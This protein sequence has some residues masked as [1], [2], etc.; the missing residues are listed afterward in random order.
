[1]V[2]QHNCNL[3]LVALGA[4]LPSSTGL[5]A[6]TLSQALHRLTDGGD[7]RL[8][9]LS[10]FWRTP[11]HPVGSGPDYI[12]A[13]A[14][15][16]TDLPPAIVLARLHATEA[17]L[18]RARDGRRWAARGIDLDL[19]AM[20][21]TILPDTATQTAWRDLPPAQ[22]LSAAPTSLILPHPRLQDRGFVL[23]PLAEIAP[24]WRHPLTGATVAAM[25]AALPDAALAGMSPLPVDFGGV[26]HHEC[27]S[28]NNRFAAIGDS[29]PA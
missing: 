27:T 16:V 9:A 22:Q 8:A 19:L 2:Y 17:D 24:R 3:A 4:N 11:A 25:L 15:M 7:M 10:R 6:Q 23:A 13:C 20:G 28:P 5:P 12:N 21:D 1:M 26:A 14:A 29:W 18:G